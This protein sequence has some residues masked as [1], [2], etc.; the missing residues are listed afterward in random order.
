[1]M[2]ET[3]LVY[4]VVSILILL[5]VCVSASQCDSRYRNRR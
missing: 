3:E 1:M 4:L 5:I 2:N